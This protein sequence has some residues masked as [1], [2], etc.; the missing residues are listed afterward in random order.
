LPDSLK[1]MGGRVDVVTAYITK[2]PNKSE[3]HSIG[4]LLSDN[5]IDILTFTSSSTARN[6]F[7]L[8]ADFKQKDKKPVIACIGPVTSKTVREF[9]YKPG[10]VSKQYTVEALAG[11][12][13]SYFAQR[14]TR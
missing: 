7:E 8:I 12:I 14:T 3:T 5:K 10:I 13:T 1:K 2:K 4:K 11:E 9:G 6:F